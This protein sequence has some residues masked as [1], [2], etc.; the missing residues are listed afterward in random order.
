MKRLLALL[1]VLGGL[2]L[3]YGAVRR[4]LA[5]EEVKI[6]WLLDEMADNF[7]RGR[8]RATTD[9]LTFDF[10]D[11]TRGVSKDAIRGY[12]TQLYFRARDPKTK[13]FTYRVELPR[14]E[15]TLE[16]LGTPH[17]AKVQLTARF[18]ERRGG[19]ESLVWE[20][21]IDADLLHSDPGWQIARTRHKTLRGRRID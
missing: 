18:H 6:G 16:L 14:S 13:E 3:G 12:L 2:Y 8:P 19:E 17:H 4:L 10:V 7:N 21:E 1:L 15:R 20:V 9:G 5:S 11:E